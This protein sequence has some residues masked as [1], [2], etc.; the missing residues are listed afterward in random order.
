MGGRG[1]RPRPNP[2]G[3]IRP[4]SASPEPGEAAAGRGSARS[5]PC[6]ADLRATGRIA[7]DPFTPARVGPNAY[8]RTLG[9]ERL[10]SAANRAW[11][12][13]AAALG[14]PPAD[15][16]RRLREAGPPLA[17]TVVTPGGVPVVLD[18]AADTPTR[19]YPIP[20][21]GI[22]LLP[23][24]VYLAAVRERVAVRDLVPVIDGRSS[25]GRLGVSGHQTAGYGDTGWDGRFTLELTAVTPVRVRPGER[26]CQVR[27]ETVEG[28]VRPYRGRS[29]GADAVQACRAHLGPLPA[30]AG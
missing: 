25:Y 23:G 4:A 17:D 27:F 21:D 1:P 22:D 8:E 30:P 6:R 12:A 26:L 19:R 16:A 18:P 29:R 14:L 28:E 15:A 7:I 20:V 3:P 11:V 24:V 5:T 9:D 2:G 13:R 10:V